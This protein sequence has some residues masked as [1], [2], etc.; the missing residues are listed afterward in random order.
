MF[1]EG[2]EAEDRREKKIKLFGI[3]KEGSRKIRES[4]T[5]CRDFLGVCMWEL[6]LESESRKERK[7]SFNREVD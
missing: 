3:N 5:P 6:E 2:E 1:G 4:T 7:K